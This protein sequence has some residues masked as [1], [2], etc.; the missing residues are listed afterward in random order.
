METHECSGVDRVF[1]LHELT[2]K[3]VGMAQRQEIEAPCESQILTARAVY[4]ERMAM[5][6][7]STGAAEAAFKDAVLA[8]ADEP[9]PQNAGRYLAASERLTIISP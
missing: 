6:V 1:S 2:R 7:V 3:P 8:F 4:R 5:S 9:S